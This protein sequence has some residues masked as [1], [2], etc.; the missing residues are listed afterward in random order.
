MQ[1]CRAQ[2]EKGIPKSCGIKLLKYL[3]IAAACKSERKIL[4]CSKD[5]PE[6]DPDVPWIPVGQRRCCMVHA[7]PWGKGWKLTSNSVV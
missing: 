7:L 1:S 2:A 5:A 4:V 3:P 6:V